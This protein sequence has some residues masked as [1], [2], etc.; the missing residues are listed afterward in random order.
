MTPIESYEPNKKLYAG[1]RVALVNQAVQSRVC[2]KCETNRVEIPDPEGLTAAVVVARVTNRVK[3]NGSEI[4]FI[5]K[6]MEMP[7]KEVAKLLD[8]SE[9]TISRWENGHQPIGGANEKIFRYMAC[10]SLAEKAPAIQWSI[11]DIMSLDIAARISDEEVFLCFERT[12]FKA[13]PTQPTKPVWAEEP[14]A[15]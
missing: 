4:K 10:K 8:V 11:D 9:E 5:R 3:L 14:Q 1:I 13:Q 6:A 15:A 7:A 2:D 12:K